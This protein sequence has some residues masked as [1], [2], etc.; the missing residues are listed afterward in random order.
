MTQIELILTDFICVNPSNQRYQC[1]IV[2]Y[3]VKW[4]LLFNYRR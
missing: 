3:P 2:F 4:I 1:S